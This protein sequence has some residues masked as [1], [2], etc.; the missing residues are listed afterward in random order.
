MAGPFFCLRPAPAW[1]RGMCVGVTLLLGPLVTSHLRLQPLSH[2]PHHCSL[3]SL[4][5]LGGGASPHLYLVL[6][7]PAGPRG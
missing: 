6:E 1:G 2:K 7:D 5:T 4:V 3:L